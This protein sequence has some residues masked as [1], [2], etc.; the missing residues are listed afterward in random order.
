MTQAWS[1]LLFIVHFFWV[2]GRRALMLCL[3]CL[4]AAVVTLAASHGAL[5]AVLGCIVGSLIFLFSFLIW[6]WDQSLFRLR[7]ED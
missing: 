1:V 2:L 6:P 4:A 3:V 7:M 5:S